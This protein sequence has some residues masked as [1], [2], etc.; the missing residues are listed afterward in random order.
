M[1]IIPTIPMVSITKLKT[2]SFIIRTIYFR[3]HFQFQRKITPSKRHYKSKALKKCKKMQN[4]TQNPQPSL[5]LPCVFFLACVFFMFR[6]YSAC[7]FF[8][9]STLTTLPPKTQPYLYLACVFLCADLGYF[10]K[11][12]RMLLRVS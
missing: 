8:P 7:V 12:R 4:Y 11:K 10:V 2:F 9:Q 5:Y 6:P 1:N 3:V